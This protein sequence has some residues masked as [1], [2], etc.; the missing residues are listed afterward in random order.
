MLRAGCCAASALALPAISQSAPAG[1]PVR[2]TITE[3]I[4]GLV[5]Q[6]VARSQG[7]F[8]EF[9]VEPEM[10]LVSDGSK[11][12]AAL[13]SDASDI[14]IG[15]GFNQV[16]PAIARGAPLKIVAGALN[17]CSLAMYSAKPGIGT[18]A[19][20]AGKVIG[21]G[22]VGAVVYQ[23]TVM[24]LRKK[25]ISV[26][27][28]RFR[29]VGSASDII[30]A[31]SAGTVDAGLGDVDLLDAPG[32]FGI[33]ALTDGRLWKELPEYTNQASY[34]S[35]EAIQK[36]RDRLVRLLAAYAKTYRFVSGPSSRG[37][38][39]HSWQNVARTADPAQALA[40]WNWI[41]RYQPYALDLVLSDAQID[42]VQRLNVEFGA[43]QDVLP[44]PAVADMSLARE[45]LGLLR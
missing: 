3:S 10:L 16:T 4:P 17:L 21:T 12:V 19:D 15:S 39:L 37:V 9:G 2:M 45:A 8:R 23:M 6:A 44:A 43:Q 1:I 25:R 11:C 31:V 7:F 34:A 24:L 14:S 33:H 28:I 41:Q 36:D 26:D 42:Y 32:K 5:L 18:V 20:L 27:R 13:V 22:A 29:N 35:D 30:R 38:F 40:H